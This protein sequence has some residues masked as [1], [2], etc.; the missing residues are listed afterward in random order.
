MKRIPITK[1]DLQYIVDNWDTK[2]V[3]QIGQKLGR[4]KHHVVGMVYTLR[5]LGIGLARK[6][7][8][9]GNRKIY[10]EFAENYLKKNPQKK[11][12]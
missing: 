12:G 1:E 8:N 11:N 2:T 5:K 3:E 4:E 10:L 7:G 9:S 6:T